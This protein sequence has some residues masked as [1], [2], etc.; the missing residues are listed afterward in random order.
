MSLI[1]KF[2]N[3]FFKANAKIENKPASIVTEKE[4]ESEKLLTFVA[5]VV[6]APIEKNNS[7]EILRDLIENKYVN[8]FAPSVIYKDEANA[9][10]KLQAVLKKVELL[11]YE[12]NISNK[13]VIAIAGSFSSGKS[14]FINSLFKSS[15]EVRLPTGM[16]RTTAISS[17]IIDD[18][19]VDITGI[20]RDGGKL[21][22]P[23]EIYKL[24]G[25]ENEKKFHFNMKRL[26]DH[27]IVKNEYV[28]KFPNLC[29]I[30]TPGFNPGSDTDLDKKTALEALANVNAFIWCVPC[31]AG[32]IRKDEFEILSEIFESKPN[33]KF[34]VIV[35]KADQKPVDEATDVLEDIY[36][37]IVN[38]NMEDYLEG[39]CL[40]S[41]NK[42]FDNQ[43]PDYS[44]HEGK[45]LLEFFKQYDVPNKKAKNEILE[46][47][48]SVFE[49]YINN[50]KNLIEDYKSVLKMLNNSEYSFDMSVNTYKTKLEKVEAKAVRDG[51][52]T[53]D[54]EP[55]NIDKSSKVFH[56]EINN[57]EFKFKDLIE[58]S[59][60]NIEKAVELK[61]KISMAFTDFWIS[62]NKW[63]SFQDINCDSTNELPKQNLNIISLSEYKKNHNSVLDELANY[64]SSVSKEESKSIKAKLIH[65]LDKAK[66][67]KSGTATKELS[68]YILSLVKNTRA[69]IQNT[70]LN[71]VKR[72]CAKLNINESKIVLPDALFKY[73]LGSNS[74]DIKKLIL[75]IEKE[76]HFAISEEKANNFRTGK[77]VM[78]YFYTAIGDKDL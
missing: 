21:S 75:A 52:L 74:L 16:T 51:G 53:D 24:F 3:L 64:L 38:N 68:E 35:N 66:T 33:C 39:I 36:D 72:I 59:N 55:E 54:G 34:Y 8:E 7:I 4:N 1:G 50:D 27:I 63:D 41:S 9:Y 45:T 30:D 25:H 57:I 10:K 15:K 14:S 12:G 62:I 70:R 42:K 28:T 17:Y 26:I 60:S 48:S 67:N 6:N 32:T 20:T 22:I 2:F 18:K 13:N 77:D 58:T 37:N 69:T 76:F 31:T 11:S 65:Y 46:E 40:Y 44:I 56:D 29:V 49:G 71:K 5:D 47:I 73:D 43:D 61:Q 23:S 19:K 78:D